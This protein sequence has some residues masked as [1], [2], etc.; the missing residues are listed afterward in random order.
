MEGKLITT[1]GLKAYT[2]QLKTWIGDTYQTKADMAL[3][4][5]TADL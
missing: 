1:E 4:T 5:K 3:Y 2:E